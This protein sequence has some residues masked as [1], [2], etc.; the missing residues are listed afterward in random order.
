MV[1]L[2][3]VHKS[4]FPLS[5]LFCSYLYSQI[6]VES[7]FSSTQ[8]SFFSRDFFTLA[9]YTP[10][11]LLAANFFPSLSFSLCRSRMEKYSKERVIKN[12][13]KKEVERRVE[14]S[15]FCLFLFES[16]QGNTSIITLLE[17]Q[18]LLLRSLVSFRCRFG[19][20]FSP[21]LKFTLLSLLCSHRSLL[22][23][24]NALFAF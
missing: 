22:L 12:R 9:L 13:N 1:L 7:F 11:L 6:S 5:L 17:K 2:L 8:F 15:F 14:K 23:S 19:S 10:L 18:K 3:G 16:Y 20:F 4:D 24:Q 21:R